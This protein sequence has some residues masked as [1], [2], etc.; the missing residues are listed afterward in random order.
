[1]ANLRGA[2]TYATLVIAAAGRYNL[3]PALLAGLVDHESNWNPRAIRQEVAIG[4]ASRGL[5]Q[6]LFRTAQSIGYTG[7]ADGLFD[8]ATN[9]EYAAK[10]LAQQIR[11]A[12]SVQGGLSAYN[13]GYNPSRGFGKVATQPLTVVLA[14]SQ[15][16]GV[17][18][19]TRQVKVGEYANQPYVDSVMANARAYAQLPAITAGAGASSAPAPLSA[20]VSPTPKGA[21]SPVPMLI[22]TAPIL[23]AAIGWKGI[24]GV[25]GVGALV[26]LARRFL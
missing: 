2:T 13:G 23:G 26:W 5:G 14:R 7:T 1:M 25:L 12:G 18:I 3:A 9:L 6:I 22:G 19:T 10:Y 8:P 16:T 17:P 24:V 21:P 15:T 4:D 11:L 20:V